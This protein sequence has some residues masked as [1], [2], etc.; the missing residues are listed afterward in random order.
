M[1]ACEL[2][3]GLHPVTRVPRKHTKLSAAASA[4]ARMP[5]TAREPRM[6]TGEA[7]AVRARSREGLARR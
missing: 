4:A 1:S 3:K 2:L 7:P 6:S 5:T